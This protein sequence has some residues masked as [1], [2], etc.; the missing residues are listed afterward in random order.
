MGP[1]LCLSWPVWAC[2]EPVMVLSWPV[3]GLSWA[4]LGLSWPVFGVSWASL[5]TVLAH[6]GLS[7]ACLGLSWFRLGPVLGHF[8]TLCVDCCQKTCWQSLSAFRFHNAARRYVHSTSATSRR[9]GRACQI[10]GTS[11]L[12]SLKVLSRFPNPSLKSI[13]LR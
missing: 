7:W 13:S 4:V 1:V 10:Q 8:W 6:L 9:A 12:S 11:C 5:G 3:L 2:L